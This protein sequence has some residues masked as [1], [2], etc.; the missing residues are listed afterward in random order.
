MPRALPPLSALAGL[1]RRERLRWKRIGPAEMPTLLQPSGN[2]E[3]LRARHD[4]PMT[5]VECARNEPPPRARRNDD[6]VR[7]AAGWVA[8]VV[9]ILE[10]PRGSQA[11]AD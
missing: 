10:G 2:G 4:L 9:G 1:G 6:R 11:A 7:L 8:S 5:C 3:E